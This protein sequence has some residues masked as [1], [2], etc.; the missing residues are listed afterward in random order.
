MESHLP[1]PID[2]AGPQERQRRRPFRVPAD[3]VAEFSW[4]PL[5]LDLA[6]AELVLF[7]RA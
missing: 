2:L 1:D 6:N 3:L 5:L 7:T 4:P